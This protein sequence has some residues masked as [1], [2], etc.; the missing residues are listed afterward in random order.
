MYAYEFNDRNAPAPERLRHLPFPVG[1]S[2]SLELRYLFDV[3][4]AGPFDPAQQRLSDVMIGYWSQFVSTGVPARVGMDGL[5]DGQRKPG[6]V[7]S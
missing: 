1:A 2:H 6:Q 7:H 5:A 4:G 3:V